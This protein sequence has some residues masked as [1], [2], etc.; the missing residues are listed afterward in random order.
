M[1]VYWLVW[2][3]AAHWIV[4]RLTAEG[5]LPH[6]ARLRAAGI[7]AAA[8][9]PA[10][11]C[12]TPPSLA[13]L[14]T[15]AWPEQ[16]GVTGFRVPGTGGPVEESSAAFAPGRCAAPPVWRTAAEAGLRTAAV[17]VPWTIGA[18][19]QAEPGLDVAVEAYSDRIDRQAALPLTGGREHFAVGP[20]PLDVTPE[21]DRIRV[22]SEGRS[23]T[24]GEEDGDWRQLRLG[25]DSGVWLR[26]V[27][28]GGRRVLLRTGAWRPRV[29]GHDRALT[30]AVAET[31]PVFAGEGI[32]PTYRTG[33]LG[34]RLVDG[35]DGSAEDLFVS[36]MGCV[37]RSFEA[38]ARTV[39][40]RHTAD[41]VVIYLPTT[42][43]L[44]HE[45]I[46][47]CDPKSAAHRPDVADRIWRH[48]RIVYGWADRLLGAVLDRARGR[49]T[50]LL[51]AD[52]GIAGTAWTVHPNEVLIAAGLAAR[53]PDGDLDPARSSVLYHPADNGSLWV[54][55]QGLPGGRVPRSNAGALL[56]RAESA[57]RA[58][59]EPGGGRPVTAGFAPSPGGDPAVVR[60]VLFDPDFLPTAKLRPDHA[61]VAPSLKPGAHITNNGDPRLHAV[62]AARGPGLPPGVDLGTV[63]N[64]V[65]AQVALHQLGLGPSDRARPLLPDTPARR[66]CTAT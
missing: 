60:H 45:L 21:G 32:G 50:V 33:G 53:T 12:Q 18:D 42:D 48:V 23:V 56:D 15:G 54:N 25:T 1:T 5:A 57:L 28:A 37:H 64:T 44:G 38:P 22:R 55:H 2:D 10:P 29:V 36:S 52:H 7:T 6:T 58:V 24:L 51:G 13:T 40:A 31:L 65:P 66:V 14:F 34:P 8:R 17:H 27:A 26:L 43:D 11:N 41:L 35:G 61:V 63:D 46:G 62:F 3:A 49:D 16:H 20:H 47:W 30:D 59:T 4:E 9:P 39:L 19:G